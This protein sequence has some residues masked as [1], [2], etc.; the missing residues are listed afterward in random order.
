MEDTL[1]IQG[2]QLYDAATAKALLE[3]LY[4]ISTF[5][6]VN[7]WDQEAVG[8]INKMGEYLKKLDQLEQEF[9]AV[10]AQSKT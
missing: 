3:R 5:A 9:N 8:E 2:L 6:E 1:R 4:A 10:E 7:I